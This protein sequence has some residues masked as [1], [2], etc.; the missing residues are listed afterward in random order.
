[1][2]SLFGRWRRVD[3]ALPPGDPLESLLEEMHDLRM[4][5][6]ADLTAAAG[7]ADAGADN[8]ARDIIEADQ[9]ELAR[10]A[11]V[12]NVRL[13]RL[14]RH[15]LEPAVDR[16]AW[17]R[18]IAVALPIAPVVGAMALSAAAATGVLP[19]PGGTHPGKAAVVRADDRTPVGSYQQLVTVLNGDPNASQVIAAAFKLHH[20]LRELMNTSSNDPGNAAEVAQLLRMEQSLL[21]SKQPPGVSVVLDATRKL[22]ARLVDVAPELRNSP[23]TAPSVI[24]TAAPHSQRPDR[25][26]ISA[27]PSAKPSAP[28]PTT[29]PRPSP[30][31]TPDPSPSSS[32]NP[33]DWPQ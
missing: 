19:I 8:V 2:A 13:E 5:L 7:A 20:Q 14:A 26:A 10:F 32:T 33:F 6:A 15:Q 31:Q 17:K 1:V 3:A 21:M 4:T 24:P 30:S 12:A 28:K 18:R 27:S 25:H 29:P 22:A 9:V 23:S 16:P 11:R